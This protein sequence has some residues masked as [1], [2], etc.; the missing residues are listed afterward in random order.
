MD[1]THN[2]RGPAGSSSIHYV[3]CF[4][5]SVQ[6]LGDIKMCVSCYSCLSHPFPL[7]RYT[8]AHKAGWDLGGGSGRWWIVTFDA[9]PWE[10]REH[11]KL[12]KGS[13]KLLASPWN[14]T[15]PG[16]LGRKSSKVRTAGSGAAKW[17][18]DSVAIWFPAGLAFFLRHLS[19]PLLG[20]GGWVDLRSDWSPKGTPWQSLT[21]AKKGHLLGYPALKALTET[22]L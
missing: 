17:H 4:L 13:K 10:C 9:S 22:S 6:V 20:S 3:S 8:P 1:R 21:A 16:A 19:P 18:R 11:Q 7:P 12:L 5:H 2:L 14:K 15:L